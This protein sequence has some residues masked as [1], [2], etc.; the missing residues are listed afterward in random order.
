MV[1]MPCHSAL[2]AKR[3]HDVRPE[4]AHLVHDI[5]HHLMKVS[6]IKLPVGVV[7]NNSSLDSQDLARG[8]KLLA[9][10]RG[11]FMIILSCAAMTC[12]LSGRQAHHADFGATVVI[13]TQ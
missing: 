1:R 13:K 8:G 10:N 11:Q 9:P 6:A 3:K 4:H 2:G 7:Q 12:C 5:A